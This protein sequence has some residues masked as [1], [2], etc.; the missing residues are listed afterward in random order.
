[1]EKYFI[2]LVN[3]FAAQKSAFG[4]PHFFAALI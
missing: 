1:M 2:Q 4:R 3:A